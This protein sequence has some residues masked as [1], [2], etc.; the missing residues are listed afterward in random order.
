[1]LIYLSK[2]GCILHQHWPVSALE[3]TGLFQHSPAHNT[4]PLQYNLSKLKP[5][6]RVSI[7]PKPSK[8]YS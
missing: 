3:T 6:Q 1:M 4:E 7:E 8:A 5:F 2:A